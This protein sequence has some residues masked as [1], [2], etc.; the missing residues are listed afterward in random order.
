MKWADFVLRLLLNAR[1]RD[2][3]S[4]D[5]LEEYREEILPTK[6]Q[7]RAR[8]WYAR[9]VLSFASPV[10]IGLALG[11]VIGVLNLAD[12]AIEPLAD[13]TPGGMLLFISPLLLAWFVV[14]FGAARRSGQ[15][16]DA[17]KAGIPA[18]AATMVVFHLAG[19]VRVNMFL[20]MI[21]H[22][23]D[24]QNLLVRFNRSGF[25]SL[26]AYAN[27]EYV[28]VAPLVVLA[29]TLAGVVTSAAGGALGGA[30]RTSSSLSR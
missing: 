10:A 12:T 4:G 23:D 27:Y 18:A 11:T 9:Q 8:L 15:F 28:R 16:R 7:F 2:T 13:D 22:R 3:I 1:D 21:R 20:D 19:I 26:R 25:H 29:G 5:L 24:W 17:V 14:G 6:G 30:I